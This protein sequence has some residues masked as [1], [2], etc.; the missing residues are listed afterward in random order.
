MAE[1]IVA[2]ALAFAISLFIPKEFAMNVDYNIPCRVAA[3]MPA[4]WNA[5]IARVK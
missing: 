1:T 4:W 2:L 3:L 5:S